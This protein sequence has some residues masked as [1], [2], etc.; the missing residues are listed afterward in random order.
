MSSSPAPVR[1]SFVDPAALMRIKSLQ[2]RAKS[3]VEG[4]YN[5]LHRSPFH[6]FSVE[7]SEYRSYSTGD[8]PKHIDWK[9][10]ARSD[11][12]FIKR[13]E[14]ETNRRCYL[15]ADLS[16]SMSY[17]SGDFSKADYA[18]T[19]AATLAYYLSMQ[20]DNVGLLTFDDAVVDFIAARHRPGHFHQI[21]GC[22]ER[23]EGG[24]GTDIEAPLNR[25][26]AL[27][28]KRGLIVVLSDLLASIETLQTNLGYLRTRGHE[29]LL[30]RVLDPTELTFPFQD[31]TM[32]EDYETSR[33]LYVDPNEAREQYLKRFSEHDET[34][35]SICNSL[36]VDYYHMPT[37]EPVEHALFNLV[38]AQSRRGRQVSRNQRAAGGQ[39]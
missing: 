29:V 37:N 34:V 7:F 9:L 13:Y 22:L 3:V 11:R 28:K 24:T 5:G 26:A 38:N 6:G 20:R 14:D 1:T 23:A 12:H 35:R 8:D 30:L 25:I 10:Y 17:G 39:R 2:L 18:R 15:V 33:N 16:K 4:F 19:V 27:V 31:A 36:G 21:L 32:I